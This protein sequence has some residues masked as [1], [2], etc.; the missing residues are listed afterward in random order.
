MD[1]QDDFDGG[2]ELEGIIMPTR[3]RVDKWLWAARFFRAKPLATQACEGGKVKV[4]G[5]RV[6]STREIVLH[7]RVSVQVGE[8]EWEVDVTHLAVQ[9]GVGPMDGETLYEET[10]ESRD[11]RA[12][13]IANRTTHHA[14]GPAWARPGGGASPAN[15]PAGHG[16]GPGPARGPRGRD[17][18]R[19]PPAGP[20]AA[21]GSGAAFQNPD[22]S[23]AELV[24]AAADAQP[25][26]RPAQGN[27][28][29]TDTNR[30]EGAR[31][32]PSRKPRRRRRGR[33]GRIR[34]GGGAPGSGG[35]SAGGG[36][37]GP[38]G[39]G[40]SSGG[41]TPGGGSPGGSSSDASA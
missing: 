36:I 6:K 20:R 34:P 18:V 35:G 3:T 5:E 15:S 39:E 41:G 25:S 13:V 1:E 16:G 17:R 28:P 14:A 23:P 4:N 26:P 22:S 27:G 10:D 29:R 31:A 24:V 38:G 7:D 33:S 9:R 12:I 37:G 8:F 19:R 21:R 40:G 32:D 30:G 2:D 11:R